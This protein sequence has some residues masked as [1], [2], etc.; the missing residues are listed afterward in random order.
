MFHRAKGLHVVDDGRTHV[1]PE[2]GRKVRRLN[3]GIG[4]FALQRFDQPGFFAANV[5]AG[6]AVN[7]NLDIESGAENVFAEKLVLACLF[8]RA[9]E[10]LRALREFASY[11]YVRRSGIEGETGDGDPFEQLVRIFMNNVAVLERP[12]LRFVGITY[13][14]N[15]LLFVRFDETPFHAA[16]KSG[17]AAAA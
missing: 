4:A 5:S 2:H 3:P 1:E 14:V 7:V 10:D 16:R 9:L 12:R 6:P 8:D 17:A 15:R 11:I 13:Q